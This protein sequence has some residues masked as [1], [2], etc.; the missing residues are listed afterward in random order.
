MYMCFIVDTF[1]HHIS[2]I[3]LKGKFLRK[4]AG[5]EITT[6]RKR[7]WQL[8]IKLASAYHL[9]QDAVLMTD[10]RNAEGA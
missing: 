2:D 5:A 10:H 6:S 7:N 3:H 1:S 4:I 8:S 9:S